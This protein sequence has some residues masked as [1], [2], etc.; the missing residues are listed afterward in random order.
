MTCSR[1]SATSASF[2]VAVI[3]ARPGAGRAGIGRGSWCFVNRRRIQ[4]YGLV[5]ALEYGYGAIVPGGR[6]PIACLFVEI[7]PHLV[8]FN[9]HPAKREARFR[10]LAPLHQAV[11]RVVQQV[12]DRFGHRS[13]LAPTP[14]Q[15][16]S[17]RPSP[18]PPGDA[19]VLRPRRPRLVLVGAP[20]RR[21]GRSAASVRRCAANRTRELPRPPTPGVVRSPAV[22]PGRRRPPRSAQ[23]RR[24]PPRRRTALRFRT[25][26]PA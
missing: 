25:G 4:E 17:P 19:A 9:V 12:A 13:P 26:A 23:S 1:R 2:Q 24:G 6:H 3:G 22:P 11:V 16:E 5:Q 21:A 7:A 8:D 20:A 18:V 14:V 10:S 15:S